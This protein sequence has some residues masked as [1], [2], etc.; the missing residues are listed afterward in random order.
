MLPI[1]V[2]ADNYSIDKSY[3]GPK[4][5]ELMRRSNDYRDA[6]TID[7]TL[8]Q[9]KLVK[10]LSVVWRRD[11]LTGQDNHTPSLS[12]F[13]HNFGTSPD[14]IKSDGLIATNAIKTG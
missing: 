3:H 8:I 11:Q 7:S 13:R 1:E 5:N 6:H 2:H 10:T 9:N 14:H 4:E 12:L